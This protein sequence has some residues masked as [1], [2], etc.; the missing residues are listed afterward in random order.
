VFNNRVLR[1]L[2]GH[3]WEEVTGQRKLHNEEGKK[4]YPGTEV[5]IILKWI[6]KM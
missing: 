5:R 6:L 1:K 4:T 2:F 3:K